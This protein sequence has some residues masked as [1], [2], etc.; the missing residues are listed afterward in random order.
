MKRSHPHVRTALRP[1]RARVPLVVLLFTAAVVPLAC[2]SKK[3]ALS[4]NA[5]VDAGGMYYDPNAPDSGSTATSGDSGAGGFAAGDGGAGGFATASAP[6]STLGAPSLSVDG[7]GA[8]V[9]VS[10]EA[11]D[12]AIDAAIMAAA[13]KAAPK[14]D[15]EGQPGRATLKEGEHFGMIVTMSP[16]RCYTIIGFSPAGNVTQLD[17]KLLT[18]PLYNIEAGKSGTGEKNQPIIG[19]GAGALCPMLPLAVPYKL[20]AAATKGAGRIGIQVFARNK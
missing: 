12:A 18:P 10:P 9:A 15:R 14:M 13:A 2:S 7:G 20:D 19:K 5:S 8:G 1:R 6:T 17:L 4:V 3:P 16:G 11:N